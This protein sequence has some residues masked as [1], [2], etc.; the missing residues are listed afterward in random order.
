MNFQVD[1]ISKVLRTVH[2]SQYLSYKQIGDSKLKK[3]HSL[4]ELNNE[5]V[6]SRLLGTWDETGAFRSVVPAE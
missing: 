4:R 1:S 6:M 5:R 2:S 3:V